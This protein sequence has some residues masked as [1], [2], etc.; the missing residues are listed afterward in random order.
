MIFASLGGLLGSLPE[1]VGKLRRQV[2]SG[3]FM[4]IDDGFL[5]RSNPIKR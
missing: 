5:K 1:T 3:G 4:I 2:R